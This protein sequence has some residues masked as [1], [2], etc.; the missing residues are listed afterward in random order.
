MLIPSGLIDKDTSLVTASTLLFRGKWES[1]FDPAHTF[2]GTFTTGAEKLKTPLMR[3]GLAA[4]LAVLPDGTR[5]LELPFAG[6]PLS[7]LAVLSPEGAGALK[8][9]EV[10]MTRELFRQMHAGLRVQN[11]AVT[12]P[13]YSLRA[14]FPAEKMLRS[15]GV[16][17][18]FSGGDFSPLT[19]EPIEVSVVLHQAVFTCDESGAEAFAASAIIHE[20]AGGGSM[21]LQPFKADRP[22]IFMVVQTETLAPLIM[23]RCAHPEA[24]PADTPAAAVSRKDDTVPSARPKGLP[25]KS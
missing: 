20:K 6:V 4:K 9:L 3:K 13:K 24:A 19:A 18:I 17:R 23:G 8:S 7:F 15:L 10:R 11:V 12:L 14:D 25:K 2:T 22:F 5:V 1:E 21:K 16:K